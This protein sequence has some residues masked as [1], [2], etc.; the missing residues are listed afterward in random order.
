MYNAVPGPGA[1]RHTDGGGGAAGDRA[2]ALL[3]HARGLASGR[4]APRR[5]PACNGRD[6]GGLGSIM[7]QLLRTALLHPRL[8]MALPLIAVALS[9]SSLDAGLLADD[10]IHRGKILGWEGIAPSR[11]PILD[12]YNFFDGTPEGFAFH[13]DHGLLPWWAAPD[14]KAAFFRPVS[15]ATHL[16]DHALWSDAPALM[17]AHSLAWLAAAVLLATLLLR[18]IPAGPP[19]A[20]GV[21]ALLFAVEDA[22]A[23]SV[24]WIANR[25]ALIAL[26]LALGALLAHDAWRRRGWT[27]GAILGPAAFAAAMLAGEAALGV[28]GYLL[29]HALFLDRAPAAR[30]A[31]ALAPY[32]AVLLAWAT[33][34]AML[35][36]GSAGSDT[37]VDPTVAPLVYLR[38]LAE[39]L[40][41]LLFA[42]WTQ[43][44]ADLWVVTP[45]G[46]QVAWALVA[47]AA[48][49]GLTALAW[50]LLR[51][52]PEARFWTAGM[53]LC[54]PPVCAAFPMDRLLLFAGLGAAGL[55]GGL[56]TWAGF[57]GEPRR[58]GRAGRR[59]VAALLVLHLPLAILLTPVRVW[60]VTRTLGLFSDAE[61]SVPDD[62]AI[63]HQDVVFVNGYEFMAYYTVLLRTNGQG[64]P[65]A[66]TDWLGHVLSDLRVERTAADALTVRAEGGF[67]RNRA[68]ALVRS[69]SRPFRAGQVIERPFMT[70]VVDRV[71]EDG[72][73]AVVTFRFDVPLDDPSLRWLVW[74]DGELRPFEPPEVGEWTRI[75]PSAPGT[76]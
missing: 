67:L 39:R 55:L 52:S 72:R 73:P 22:H 53:V 10:W 23:S 15:A 58:A 54:L 44:T 68:E 20:G 65:P 50:P 5:N 51:S 24:T 2:Q 7:K 8:S 9:C 76:L 61:K 64:H 46:A 70:V 6:P 62:E 18:R 36:Y 69:R 75:R 3:P 30:R 60:G 41:V 25:N 21:A 56:A 4:A 48:L 12:L 43:F 66:R 27:P 28:L 13:V 33:A 49:A 45:V 57:Y 34:F 63:A 38:A 31:A 37:Y 47:A 14:V 29:A 16:L 35:G 59:M 26:T 40:P 42:Q 1:A 19:I 74:V 11:G 32:G 17:H 71:T